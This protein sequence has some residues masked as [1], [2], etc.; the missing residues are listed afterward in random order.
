MAVTVLRHSDTEQGEG[1]SSREYPYTLNYSRSILLHHLTWE[2]EILTQQGV[3]Y[4]GC[5]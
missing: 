3:V 1:H 5:F 2:Y 4:I